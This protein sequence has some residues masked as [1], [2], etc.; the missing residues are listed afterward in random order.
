MP[1]TLDGDLGDCG[2]AFPADHVADD[3]HVRM[4]GE[5]QVVTHG[6]PPGTIDLQSDLLGQEVVP[7]CW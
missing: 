6:D 5:G 2:H 4:S 7:D 1:T 3:E